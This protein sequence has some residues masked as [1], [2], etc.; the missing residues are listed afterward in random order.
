[1]LNDNECKIVFIT[2]LFDAHRPA[3]AHDFLEFPDF[4][5]EDN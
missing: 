3:V 4:Q 1:M 2:W 5:T